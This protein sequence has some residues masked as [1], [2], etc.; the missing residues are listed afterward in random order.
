MGRPLTRL[1]KKKKLMNKQITNIRNKTWDITR[2]PT[3]NK[4]IIQEYY[5]LL[6]IHKFDNLDKMDHFL[7]KHKLPKLTKYEIR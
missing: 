2:D 5:K 7:E 1:T 6:Y 4:R 3:D